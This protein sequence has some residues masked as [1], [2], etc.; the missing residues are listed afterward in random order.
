M[1][2]LKLILI[3][4]TLTSCMSM[5]FN[6]KNTPGEIEFSNTKQG[7]GEFVQS[8]SLL[9]DRSWFLFSYFPI[10]KRTVSKAVKD[11]AIDLKKNERLLSTTITTSHDFMSL[12]ISSLTQSI[13]NTR[14]VEISAIATD[15]EER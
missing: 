6:R 1:N 9:M 12:I 4:F 2:M 15:K 13:I 3:F 14:S 10:S 5:E 8:D 11:D 7:S